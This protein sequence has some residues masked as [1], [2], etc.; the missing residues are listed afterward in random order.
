MGDISTMG[1]ERLP[2]LLRCQ[3]RLF[4]GY[5]GRCHG[6]RLLNLRGILNPVTTARGHGSPQDLFEISNVMRI[7]KT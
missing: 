6:I 7:G 3:F 5:D 4:Q 1:I 2:N